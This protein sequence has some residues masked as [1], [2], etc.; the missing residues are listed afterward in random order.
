MAQELEDLFNSGAL[1]RSVTRPTSLRLSE[2]ASGRSLNS[3]TSSV[4]W[5]ESSTAP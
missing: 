5:I 4:W 3:S 2:S 1:V